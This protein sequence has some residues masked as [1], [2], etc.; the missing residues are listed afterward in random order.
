MNDTSNYDLSFLCTYFAHVCTV[1]MYVNDM[2]TL[3]NIMC[4]T[5]RPTCEPSQ[6]EFYAFKY[7][8]N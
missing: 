5:S 6:P 3:T 1:D 7:C 8:Y 2:L 4:W